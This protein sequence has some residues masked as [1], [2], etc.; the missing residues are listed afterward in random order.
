MRGNVLLITD[1]N[2][3]QRRIGI[4]LNQTIDQGWYSKREGST[5]LEIT[6]SLPLFQAFYIKRKLENWLQNMDQ[7]ISD[8]ELRDQLRNISDDMIHSLKKY[9]SPMPTS[10]QLDHFPLSECNIQQWNMDWLVEDAEL[11]LRHL[12]GRYWL[13]EQIVKRLE[14][15]DARL[16]GITSGGYTYQQYLPAILQYLYL[17]EEIE[18]ISGITIFEWNHRFNIRCERCGSENER[19]H[20]HFCSS[21]GEYDLVCD[22]CYVMGSSKGCSVVVSRPRVIKETLADYTHQLSW[23]GEL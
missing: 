8:I 18:Y 5:I 21:C 17:A 3:K 19:I 14:M 15:V 23:S 1:L 20:S 12:E 22:V 13:F 7:T 6:P 2:C 16:K 11:V 9:L 10:F 4:S